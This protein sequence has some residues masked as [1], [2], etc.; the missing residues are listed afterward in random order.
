M[1][2]FFSNNCALTSS[3][4]EQSEIELQFS[5]SPNPFEDKLTITTS[6]THGQAYSIYNMQGQRLISGITKSNSHTIDVSAL[7]PNT[8]LI[9]I[10]GEVRKLA[11][12]E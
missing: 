8:Y 6:R 12:V 3:T 7:A 9:N 10:G 1:W 4:E 11:K 2:D 5:I